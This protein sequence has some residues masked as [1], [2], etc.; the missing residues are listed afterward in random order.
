MVWDLILFFISSIQSI[1]LLTD[2]FWREFLQV[3]L[4]D[5]VF[6][7]LPLQLAAKALLLL[8]SI[9]L[10]YKWN[11]NKTNYSNQQGTRTLEELRETQQ[12]LDKYLSEKRGFLKQIQNLEGQLAEMK[13][14]CNCQDGRN[15]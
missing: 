13:K 7:I 5:L 3:L 1:P 6:G 12:K 11:Q 14:K 4:K 15:V 9:Y 8:L 2:T 10:A